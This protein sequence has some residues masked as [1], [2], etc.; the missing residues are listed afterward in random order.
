MDRRGGRM[1][2]TQPPPEIGYDEYVRVQ[3]DRSLRMRGHDPRDRCEYLIGVLSRFL[4]KSPPP[5]VLCVGCR[6]GHELDHLAS[7]GYPGAVGIDLHSTDP[8]IRVMDMHELR[9]EDGSF[10][11]VY[12][13][14]S[15]EHAYDVRK[16]GGEIG[17][18]LVPGGVAIV[19]VPIACERRKGDMWDLGDPQ[20]IAEVIGGRLEWSEVGMQLGANQRVARAVVRV[21]TA[22]GLGGQGA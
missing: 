18:V 16:A 20:T 8:R 11:A 1:P 9:F 2:L 7:A 14:H 13:C 17:R 10:E 6:N 22:G 4:A 5:R 12:S 15:L 19:E 21:G 3:M